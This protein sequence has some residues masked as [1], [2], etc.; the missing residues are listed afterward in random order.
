[1]QPKKRGFFSQR[2]AIKICENISCEAGT[3]KHQQYFI[4]DHCTL[5]IAIW[6]GH[7][8]RIVFQKITSRRVQPSLPP[9]KTFAKDQKYV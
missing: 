5:Q 2:N 1:M 9:S 6:N 3:Q 8:C 4:S 7:D